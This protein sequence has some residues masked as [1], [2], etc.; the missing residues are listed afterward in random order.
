MP[1]TWTD[2]EE[3]LTALARVLSAVPDFASPLAV[4]D[5]PGG[6]GKRALAHRWAHTLAPSYPDGQVV[7]DLRATAP[8][9]PTP[10]TETLRSLLRALGH[11]T[12]AQLPW[13]QDELEAMLRSAT[14]GRRLLLVLEDAA[15]AEQVTPLLPAGPSCLVVVTSRNALPGLTAH[16]AVHHHLLP[17]APD[18]SRALLTRVLGA[19]RAAEDPAALERIAAIC[20]HLPRPLSLMAA[21]LAHA[22]HR[23]LHAAAAPAQPPADQTDNSTVTAADAAYRGLPDD[24]AR[25]YRL[26][27]AVPAPDLDASATAAATRLR[28]DEARAHLR[29]LTDRAL[30]EAVGE[31]PG[32]GDVYRMPPEIRQHAQQRIADHDGPAGAATATL[33]YLDYLLRTATRAERLLAPHHRELPRTYH[34]P[35]GEETEFTDPD[36][37]RT[38]LRAHLAALQPAKDAARRL[39]KH[40]F[41]WQITHALWPLWQLDRPIDA[42][43]LHHE[44]GLEAAQRCAD[45]Q[46]QR[47]MSSALALGL[48]YAQRYDDALEQYRLALTLAQAA[49]DAEGIAQ[50]TAGLGAVLHDAGRLV[51]A[52]PYLEAAIDLYDTLGRP[53]GAALARTMA[54]SIAA[55]RRDFTTAHQLLDR[56]RTDLLALPTPDRRNAARALARSGEAHSLQGHHD[57]AQHLLLQARD[58]FTAVPDAHWAARVTEYLGQDD[59]RAGRHDQATAQYRDSLARYEALSS[60]R[61]ID[62]LQHHLQARP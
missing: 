21:D 53:R 22:P 44:D 9:G 29:L 2:R 62:R 38:W 12:D 25:V 18:A 24:S 50:Y 11:P 30:L 1:A 35:A 39:R 60:S 59:D 26:L 4:I 31:A 5:G 32:R 16:G 43:I 37:A 13:P 20:G 49:D 8:G 23:R 47:E 19:E 15:N 61:D 34:H 52:A 45:P 57:Q 33:S 6:A 27:A 10:T 17:F 40:T 41:R 3:S 55:T 28:T 56:A 46:A 14:A 54:G 58:E 36:A 7:T 51:L 48:T 42:W